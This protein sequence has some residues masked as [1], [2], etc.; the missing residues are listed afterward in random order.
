LGI[1]YPKHYGQAYFH[2]FVAMMNEKIVGTGLATINDNV[3]W[4]GNI[5]VRQ[6][7][8]NKGIGNAITTHL[9][10]F[11]KSKG[12]DSILLFATEL[13]L[14]VYQKIGFQYDSSYLFFKSE[15]AIKI[16]SLSKRIYPVVEADYAAILELD[17]HITGEKREKLLSPTLKTGFKFKAQEIEGIYLPDFGKGLIISNSETAGIELLKY[18]LSRDNSRLCIPETNTTAIKLF[19]EIG[20]HQYQ[21]APRL[22]LNN[23]IKWNPSKIYSRGCGYFG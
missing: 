20:L 7:N 12:I 17:Y 18:R 14:P 21:R 15:K 19:S 16:E 9:V 22:F 6:S 1:E 4:L 11:S 8:R 10:N 5:I 13:G 3:T 2:P 23:N